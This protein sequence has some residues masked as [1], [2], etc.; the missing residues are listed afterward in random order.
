MAD[1]ERSG[2]RAARGRRA[3]TRGVG[4]A[5]FAF[6]LLRAA[7]PAGA[8][9]APDAGFG[10]IQP[11]EQPTPVPTLPALPPLDVAATPAAPSTPPEAG[12]A[13][14]T[15]GAA[16]TPAAPAG[17]VAGIGISPQVLVLLGVGVLVIVATIIV[18]L[19]VVLK[20]PVVINVTSRG[21]APAYGADGPAPAEWIEGDLVRLGRPPE[22]TLKI[23]PGRF[24]LDSADRP[25][26]IRIFRTTGDSRV[27]TTI[28]RDPGPPYRHI[29]LKPFSVSGKHAKLVYEN[30]FYS[31]V[32]YSRTNPTSVNAEPLPEGASRR[33]V[34][35]DRLEIGEV[36]LTYHES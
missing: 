24:V 7:T 36:L 4:A 3:L 1:R 15:A 31:I 26:E 6:A 29:Q 5:L 23:L 28:G 33:L 17:P 2:R 22:G 25:I 34:D 11:V 35:E 9:T 16:E 14:S 30:G 32:N 27:E 19:A 21:A 8:Q 13:E 10:D 20:A 18:V 12:A